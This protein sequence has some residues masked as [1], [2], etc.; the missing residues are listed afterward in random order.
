M[1]RPGSAKIKIGCQLSPQHGDL[2]TLRRAW[3]QAEALG[4][5]RLYTFDH[6]VAQV[7]HADVIK[8]GAPPV[9][10]FTAPCFEATTVQAAMAESTTRAEIGCLVHGNGYRNPHM[11]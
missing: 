11:L 10:D 5:D 9:P 3:L 8:S 4:A 2:E 6:F 1:T 7:L